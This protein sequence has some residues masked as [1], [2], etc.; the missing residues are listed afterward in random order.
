MIKL[1]IFVKCVEIAIYNC[2]FVS[3]GRSFT[4]G[5]MFELQVITEELGMNLDNMELEMLGSCKTVCCTRSIINN[6]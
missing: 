1:P 6:K 5:V 2:M 3:V 4:M